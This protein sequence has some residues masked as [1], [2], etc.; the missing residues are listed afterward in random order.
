MCAVAEEQVF[1]EVD[2]DEEHRKNVAGAGCGGLL[3]FVAFLVFVA[4]ST[5]FQI[6]NLNTFLLPSSSA[7]P[8][9]QSVKVEPV[10]QL[11]PVVQMEQVVQVEQP[12]QGDRVKEE[13]T[14]EEMISPRVDDPDIMS[15]TGITLVVDNINDDLVRLRSAPYTSA[16][17][18]VS[19]EPGTELVGIR[20]VSGETVNKDN[21]VWWEVSYNG[22]VGYIYSRLVKNES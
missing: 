22:T 15:F 8:T 12:V 9:A 2:I 13:V 21:D 11:E 19:L 6:P 10:L 18:L 7:L 14:I 20:T 16:G 17:I 5:G 1:T 4:N 3:V